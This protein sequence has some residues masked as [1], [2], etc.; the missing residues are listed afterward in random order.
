MGIKKGSTRK[1]IGGV[2]HT[3]IILCDDLN[4]DTNAKE[5]SKFR[6]LWNNGYSL[7]DIAA[8]LRREPDEVLIMVVDQS[9]KEHINA[10]YGGY[11]GRDYIKDL[12][13]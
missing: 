8:A 1:R 5:L 12:A 3:P 13:N 4:L 6:D 9:R 2:S 11:M 7:P 10:R